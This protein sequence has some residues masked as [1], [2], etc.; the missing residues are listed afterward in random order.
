MH[1]AFGMAIAYL[2]GSIPFALLA[3]KARGV[4]LREHGSGNLG[5]T[6][7]IRILGPAVGALVYLGDTLKGFIPVVFLPLLVTAGRR[8]I[9]A[10]AY[11]AAAI[12]GHVFPIFLKGKRGGKGVATAGGVF[13]AL[14][15]LPALIAVASFAGVLAAIRIVSVASM[16]AALVL[17]VAIYFWR[18]AGDPLFAMSLAIAAFVL[19]THR[20]NVGRLRHGTEPRVTRG[21]RNGV[22]A[23]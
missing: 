7:A 21:S 14:A 9:W 6:N 20:A 16:T 8:D 13:F 12:L 2:A 22:R 19:F 1:P 18:D 10:I 4:D 15:W 17:P 11:G 23:A 3:G 5:T